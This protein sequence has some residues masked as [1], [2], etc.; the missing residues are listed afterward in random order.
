MLSALFAVALAQSSQDAQPLARTEI[1][2]KLAAVPVFG[3]F[4]EAGQ[5]M[6]NSQNQI[7]LFI[8]FE[9]A[10]AFLKE[11]KSGSELAGVEIKTLRLDA[12]VQAMPQLSES[13]FTIVIK[14]SESELIAANALWSS[15]GRIGQIVGVPVFVISVPDRGYLQVMAEGRP[16]T[17]LFL[18]SDDAKKLREDLGRSNPDLRDVARVEVTTLDTILQML[19]VNPASE[20]RPLTFIAS[21]SALEHAKRLTE[22]AESSGGLLD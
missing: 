22:G 20:T 12:V 11:A 14:P 13:G 15:Q 2:R 9:D 16:A 21:K 19:A 1:H 3:A 10:E 8:E 17:P 6:A 4:N 18:K 7:E 5:P